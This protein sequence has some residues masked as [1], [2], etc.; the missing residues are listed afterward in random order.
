[1]HKNILVMVKILNSQ[2]V[3]IESLHVKPITLTNTTHEQS[4]YISLHTYYF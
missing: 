4:I 1:M 3:Q 2:V